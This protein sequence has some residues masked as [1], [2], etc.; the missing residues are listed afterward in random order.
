M[1]DRML[2]FLRT[3]K[4]QK[5]IVD[6]P[7]Y[8]SDAASL[9]SP[10]QRPNLKGKLVLPTS[11]AEV[12]GAAHRNSPKQLPGEDATEDDVRYFLYEVLTHKEHGL[13]REYPQ[14]I[15]ETCM[16]WQGGGHQL[17]SL[18]LDNY[19]QL[20]PLHRGHAHIDRTVKSLKFPVQD[21]PICG[22]RDRVAVAVRTAVTT[23]KSSETGHRS[24][25]WQNSNEPRKLAASRSTDCLTAQ[26]LTSPM[27][28]DLPLPSLAA[29]PAYPTREP[30]YSL[31][32][33][34]APLLNSTS[35]LSIYRDPFFSQRGSASVL[36]RCTP[37]SIEPVPERLGPAN[38]LLPPLDDRKSRQN[39]S[40]ASPLPVSLPSPALSYTYSD[41]MMSQTSSST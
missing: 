21:M 6:F 1:F 24:P 4:K 13:V 3:K 35:S 19:Q 2:G 16:S 23:L 5:L 34:S 28:L 25:G 40:A 29:D 18:P 14:W 27:H 12:A 7:Q 37:S 10:L 32:N 30:L 9:H 33:Q 17:R 8:F 36:S 39:S 22:T 11:L 38:G 15:L 20:C 31:G 26:K 41:G